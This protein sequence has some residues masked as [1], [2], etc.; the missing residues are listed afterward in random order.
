M[1]GLYKIFVLLFIIISLNSFSQFEDEDDDLEFKTMRTK[2][3]RIKNNSSEKRKF[4]IHLEAG[5][6]L[7][8][9]FGQGIQELQD[10]LDRYKNLYNFDSFEVEP[11]FFPYAKI[12]TSFN[13]TKSL[14]LTLGLQF[15][16]LGWK[17]HAKVDRSNVKYRYFNRLDFYYLGMPI[18]LNIHIGK[19][20]SFNF[21]N[22]FSFLIKNDLQTYEYF[23]QNGRLNI[24]KTTNES[25]E[26]A[27][28]FK[29]AP[30]LMQSF[31]GINAGTSRIRFALNISSTLNFIH[32]QIPYNSL[33][34][35]AGVIF[36]I[37]DDYE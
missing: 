8:T 11:S 15:N 26:D 31:I 7:T 36:K 29:A 20:F 18:A 14:S 34:V 19:Y 6:S 10:T 4:N 16:R 28:G 30:F 13:F 23:M 2:K 33:S 22:N 1:K 3:I 21:G 37:L 35:E 5:Y 17:E 25:F 9:V 32:I 24:D 12:N 27:F